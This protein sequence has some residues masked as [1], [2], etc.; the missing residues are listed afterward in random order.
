MLSPEFGLTEERIKQLEQP[1]TDEQFKWLEDHGRLDNGKTYEENRA[2]VD[3]LPKA[4]DTA[5]DRTSIGNTP[6]CDE[7]GEQHSQELSCEE[8]TIQA[9]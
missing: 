5:E 6:T 4:A 2:E 3:A 7:C 9:Y 1:V 8:A